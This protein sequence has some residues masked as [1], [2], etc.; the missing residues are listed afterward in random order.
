MKGRERER[1]GDLMRSQRKNLM[2]REIRKRRKQRRDID[3]EKYRGES[4]ENE[5]KIK[6]KDKHYSYSILALKL[7]KNGRIVGPCA[8]VQAKI[9]EK[10]TMGMAT[11]KARRK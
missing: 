2:R 3:H 6:D 4:S 10:K 8:Y 11:V 5:R 1:A 9:L 7:V